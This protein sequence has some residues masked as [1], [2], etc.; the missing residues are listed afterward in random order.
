VEARVLVRC[1]R[2]RRDV[3]VW[4]VARDGRVRRLGRRVGCCVAHRNGAV[5]RESAGWLARTWL[6]EPDGD[7]TKKG[8]AR[9]VACA[10]GRG[11]ASRAKAGQSFSCRV[12]EMTSSAVESLERTCSPGRDR[13]PRPVTTGRASSPASVDSPPLRPPRNRTPPPA[14]AAPFCATHRPPSRTAPMTGCWTVAPARRD[15]RGSGL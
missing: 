2:S 3:R 13:A 8:C 1:W 14:F 5:A 9:A 7:R 6:G 12:A 4:L 10:T 11:V 15:S